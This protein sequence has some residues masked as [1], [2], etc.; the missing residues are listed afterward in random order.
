MSLERKQSAKTGDSPGVIPE[1]L[2]DLDAVGDTPGVRALADYKQKLDIWWRDTRDAIN[3]EL[4]DLRDAN[5]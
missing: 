4:K 2:P 5:T 1:T 3:R